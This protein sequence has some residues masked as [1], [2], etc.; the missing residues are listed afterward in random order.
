[1]DA[2]SDAAALGPR[3]LLRIRNFRL[4]WLGQVISD[5]GDSLT[6]MALLILVNRLTGSTAA[7]ALMSIVLAV[8][9]VTFG[10]IAG[11]YVDRLDRKRIMIFSDLLRGVMVLG[12][13]FVDSP[14][15][16]WL[17]YVIAFIQASIGTFFTPARS[18]I[19]PALV[20]REGLLAAN[21]L[22]QTSRVIMGVAGV[23][24][25]G[26]VIGS[27]DV[28]WPVFVGDSLTFF[29]SLLVISRI[30][31]SGQLNRVKEPANVR[32]IWS[33]L[34]GGLRVIFGNRVLVGT[35]VAVG[36]TMLGMG[37]VNV[38]FVPLAVN[39]LH[40]P[41]IWFG[42]LE[43]AQ[44]LAMVLSGALV[45]SIAARLKP[46]RMISPGLVVLGIVTALFAA[47]QNVWHL[48]I[49]LFA[50]GGTIPPIQASVSTLTQTAIPDELRGRIGAALGMMV[51]T[52]NLLS[53]AF[54]GLFGELVGIRNVFALSG[55]VVVLAGLA[56]ARV[57][58]VA[59]LK[60]EEAVPALQ[61][62]SG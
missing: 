39:E 5:F 19:L 36:V 9:Q 29:A 27:L 32:A 31:V 1:M 34:S 25:A 45:A 2:T 60:T 53:M 22:A 50:M 38:L 49:I 48:A 17:L 59:A 4:L 16:I 18:A 26:L 41:E 30:A 11:V 58:A 35:L 47:A 15:R 40:M 3:G 12:F 61:G 23:S 43:F 51:T 54:A 33:E 14:D 8:P 21:S 6:M 55:V 42:A 46:T 44:T 37:A 52:A 10:L 56:S 7:L 62:E 57:F 20:P 13:I 28:F 24:A